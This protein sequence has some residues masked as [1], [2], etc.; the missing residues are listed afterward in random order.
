MALPTFPAADAKEGKSF[1]SRPEGTTGMLA[2]GGMALGAWFAAPAILSGLKTVSAILGTLVG[3]AAQTILLVLLGILLFCILYVATNSKFQMLAKYFF[4]SVMRKITGAFVE[5]DPI[6]IM[7]SYIDSMTEKRAQIGTTRDKLR[8][9]IKVLDEKISKNATVY[10]NEMAKAA[11]AKQKGNMAAVTVS[12]RQAI[13]METLNKAD[14]IPLKSQM[15]AHLRAANKYYEV[16]GTVIEDLTNEVDAQATRRE[17]IASSYSVMK[18]A[19]AIMM[20]GTDEREL[21]DQALEYTVNDYGMKLGEIESFIENSKP[22]VDGLDMQNG[23]YEAEALKRL[24]EWESKADSILLGN[25]K[26][27]LLEQSTTSSTVFT[28]I[29]VPAASSVDYAQLL[30]K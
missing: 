24:Q 18:A 20:G 6:G 15:E 23:V 13:R 21:F 7:K 27:K 22:F 12:G 28:G 1:W 9:Q 29:G 2:I 8:G 25:E 10:E 14:L 4:K 16:T 30:K 19:K 11:I 5:I 26:A 3:I 17:M